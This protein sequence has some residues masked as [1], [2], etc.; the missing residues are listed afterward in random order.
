MKRSTLFKGLLICFGLL[1]LCISAKPSGNFNKNKFVGKYS[2]GTNLNEGPVGSL[3]LY[4]NSDSTSYFYLELFHGAPSYRSNVLTGFIKVLDTN[5][6]V[7][8]TQGQGGGC[9]F[10]LNLKDDK[11]QITTDPQRSDCFFFASFSADGTYKCKSSERPLYY[12]DRSADTI[13]FENLIKMQNK[14]K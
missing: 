8:N 12:I 3:H 13:Y 4:P 9:I 6:A 1:A 14:K 2:Y 7:Y 10:E 5:R 11:I